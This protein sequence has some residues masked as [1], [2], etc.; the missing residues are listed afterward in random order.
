MPKLS[1]AFKCGEDFLV[2]KVSRGI[3]GYHCTFLRNKTPIKLSIEK[4]DDHTFGKALLHYYYFRT[5]DQKFTITRKLFARIGFHEKAPLEMEYVDQKY[6]FK[7]PAEIEGRKREIQMFY[8]PIVERL[9]VR[10]A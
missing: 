1:H 10:L 5:S 6:K 8:S 7:F 9:V 2:V 3:R 4:M